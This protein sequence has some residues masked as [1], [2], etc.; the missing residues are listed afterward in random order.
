MM[1]S[2]Q[3]E[4]DSIDRFI[5]VGAEMAKVPI[6]ANPQYRAAADDLYQIARRLLDANEN[7]ARWLNRFLLF[8]FRDSNARAHFFD[9]VTDYRSTKAGGGFRDMKFSCGDIYFIYQRN[10]ADKIAGIFPHDREAVEETKRAFTALGDSDADMV[11]F[12]W[13][14]VVTGIDGFIRDAEYCVDRSDLNGAEE[15]RLAFKVASAQLSERLERFESGLSDLVL[16]YA[17]LANRPV[18]LT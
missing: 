11:A 1:P 2:S 17:R 10:I 8:D 7:M 14:T 3:P 13:G 5:S 6:L 16:Q 18:T 12:I 9:L 4:L 15:R